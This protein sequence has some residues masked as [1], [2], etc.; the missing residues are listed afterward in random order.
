[1]STPWPWAPPADVGT[2]PVASRDTPRAQTQ[3]W[4]L[5]FSL[6]CR[7]CLEL[8][9]REVE[10]LRGFEQGSCKPAL[11]YRDRI[12]GPAG[13]EAGHSKARDRAVK[14]VMKSRHRQDG[15]GHP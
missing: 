15:G 9:R 6:C 10:P 3:A 4:D 5:N 8:A 13:P 12:L 7:V 2:F 1:M 14:A 11:G